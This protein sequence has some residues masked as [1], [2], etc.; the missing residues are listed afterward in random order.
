[1]LAD[2]AEF[3]EKNHE[4]LIS[5]SNRLD[6]ALGMLAAHLK[7]GE[8]QDVGQLSWIDEST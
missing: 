3:K 5:W 2:T 1:M 6:V 4:Q 7:V 8:E